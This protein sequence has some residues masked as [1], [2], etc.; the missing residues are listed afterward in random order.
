ML[1]SPKISCVGIPRTSRAKTQQ[2]TVNKLLLFLVV[3][4]LVCPVISLEESFCAGTGWH[5]LHYTGQ[6]YGYRTAGWDRLFAVNVPWT[7]YFWSVSARDDDLSV[8]NLIPSI[9]VNFV[10]YRDA[11][12][13]YTLNGWLHVQLERPEAAFHYV[14]IWAVNKRNEPYGSF[15]L[16]ADANFADCYPKKEQLYNMSYAYIPCSAGVVNAETV[17]Y[18][19]YE[20]RAKYQILTPKN[21]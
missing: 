5:N 18:K 7:S 4:L 16:T 11:S 13:Q 6:L 10:E 21:K 15:I 20:P 17:S 14:A 8:G 12:T 1:P 3:M 9:S 19:Y 2:S